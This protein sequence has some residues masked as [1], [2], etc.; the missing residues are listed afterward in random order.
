MPTK[1]VAG[2]NVIRFVSA[3]NAYTPSGVV[4]LDALHDG[5]RCPVSHNFNVEESNVAVSVDV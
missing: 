2:V 3:F 5:A 1:F 4:T